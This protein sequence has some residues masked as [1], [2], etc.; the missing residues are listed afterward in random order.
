MHLLRYAEISPDEIVDY[1][2]TCLTGLGIGILASA[3]VSLSPTLEDIP[4]AG[5]EV[6]R[7]AF[8]LGV[9]V[10]EVSQNLDAR[11]LTSSTEPWAYVVHDLTADDAQKELNAIHTREV[12]IV[13]SCSIGLHCTVAQTDHKARKHPTLAKSSL[14]HSVVLQ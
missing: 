9:L 12:S 3:A 5:A 1:A 2:N 8:R 6:V 14:A 13:L 11:D 10:A 7:I 4:L